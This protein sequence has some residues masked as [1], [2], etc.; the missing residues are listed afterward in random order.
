MAISAFSWWT[1]RQDVHLLPSLRPVAHSSRDCRC[2]LT[3]DYDSTDIGEDILEM[4]AQK[5]RF[6][7]GGGVT[8]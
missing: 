6:D 5:K 7:M 1:G 4:K 2:W 3:F 8:A